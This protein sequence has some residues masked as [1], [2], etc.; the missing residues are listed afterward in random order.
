[1]DGSGPHSLEM[2]K[3]R[4]IHKQLVKSNGKV[5]PLTKMGKMRKDQCVLGAE[6]FESWDWTC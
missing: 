4:R 1:M 2:K 6:G 5:V 3:G